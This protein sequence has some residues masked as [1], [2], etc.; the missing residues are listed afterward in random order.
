MDKLK[1]GIRNYLGNAKSSRMTDLSRTGLFIGRMGKKLTFKRSG[2]PLAIVQLGA[3][4]QLPLHPLVRY[5][6]IPVRL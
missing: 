2:R 4:Q 6:R 3:A 1:R 5:E